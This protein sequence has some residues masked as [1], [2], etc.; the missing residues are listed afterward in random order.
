[1]LSALLRP[2]KGSSSRDG[3]PADVEQDFGARPSVAEYRNHPHA[4]ADFTEADDDDDEEESI[5]GEPSGQQTN[6]LPNG[7]VNDPPRSNEFLPLFTANA[8]HLDSIPIYNITHAIR[9]VVQTRTETTLSWDQLRSPQVTQFLIK[10]MLQQIR[11]QHFCRGTLYALLANCLQ[12]E[13]EGQLYPGTA[14]TS[15]TRAKVCELLAIKLLKE[16]T[17]REL[18]DALCYDF[19]PLQGIPGTQTPLASGGLAKPSALRTST[20]EVAIRASAQQFLSHPLVVQKIKAIWNGAISFSSPKQPQQQPQRQGSTA[21]AAGSNSNNSQSRRQSNNVNTRTPLLGDQRVAKE[22][23]P[24]LSS[25]TAGRRAVTLYNPRTASPFK[26]SRLRVPRY[27]RLFSTCSLFVLIGLFLAVLGQRSSTITSLELLFWFWSAGFML[28]EL[29]GFNE[30]GFSFYVMSFWNIFDLGILLLLIVYYCMRIYGVFLLD[31]HKLNQNA[32]DV[33]AVNA[34]L[35]LPRIFGVLDHYRQFSRLLISFRLLAVDL[36]AVC[37]PILVCCSGFFVFLAFSKGPDDS[38]AVAFKMFQALIGFTA[39]AWDLWSSYNWMGQILLG[40]FLIISHF[41][42]ITLLVTVLANSFMS[43]SSRANEE[44]QFNF[45][46]NTIS[47]ARNNVLFSYVAPGNIFAWALMPLRYC[48]SLEQYVWMN[49]TVIKATHFPLLFCIFF[50]ER[51]FLAPDVFDPTDLVD[52]PRRERTN[53]FSDSAFFSPSVRV[54]EESVAGFQK[55]QALEEVFRRAPDMRSQRR[56][57][58]RKTQTEIRSWMDQQ[59]QEAGFN[60]PRNFSTIDSRM[61]S[62]WMRRLSMNRERPSRIPRHYSD[63]RSTASDPADFI[64]DAPYPVAVPTSM[65]NDGVIRRDHAHAASVKEQVDAAADGDD[66]LVTNDEDEG[67]DATNTIDGRG[68]SGANVIDEDYFT[69]P[70]GTRFS[71]GDLVDS[72][73]PPTSRRVPLHTRTLSTNTILYAPEEDGHPY[74]SSSAS[75]HPFPRPPSTRHGLVAAPITPGNGNGN[76]RR[77]SPRRSSPRRSFYLGPRPRSMIQPSNRAGSSGLTLDIPTTS[78]VYKPPRRRS[79]AD[80]LLTPSGYDNSGVGRAGTGTGPNTAIGPGTGTFSPAG[81]S[82]SDARGGAG[83]EVNKLMLA[84][85][86]SLEESLGSMVKEMRTLRRRSVPNTAA[87][88]DDGVLA[89]AAKLS[90]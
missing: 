42:V 16:Y 83:A 84:R 19:Y 58:R 28:D 66:E 59:Q 82:S 56:T 88:S 54:R 62:D 81:R 63:I 70:V 78:P 53:T 10:P 26:L 79:L 77:S 31:P 68:F 7:D 36:V 8:N 45:A 72:P 18:I 17:T 65:Y 35:L 49:R 32:Y 71:S 22:E 39:P 4:T 52:N 30:E 75:A 90:A 55:D 12:F 29:V 11:S 50:Y 38:L 9:I 86:K 57:E 44:Y 5:G 2:F 40:L 80:L 64:F 13:K 51:F 41:I 23:P 34:I 85:M 89:S 27:R 61:S 46:V 6:G 33:L 60:S 47:M 43:I 73:R 76:G 3:D 14:G 25:F 24:R 48:M 87:N 21:S 67:D 69:T 15:A 20:L 37:V 74:S 1:M